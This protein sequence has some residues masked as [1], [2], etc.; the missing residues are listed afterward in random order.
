[1]AKI[2][3]LKRIIEDNKNFGY[4]IIIIIGLI[5]APLFYRIIAENPKYNGP[6]YYIYY[7]TALVLSETLKNFDFKNFFYFYKESYCDKLIFLLRIPV[8]LIFGYSPTIFVFTNYIVNI[9]LL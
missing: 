8:M 2:Q 1:M 9:I 7:P 5:M 3:Y 4:F 6:H